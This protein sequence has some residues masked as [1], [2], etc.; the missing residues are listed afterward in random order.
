MQ[1][2]GE[3]ERK[4]QAMLYGVYGHGA[5]VV[6]LKEAVSVWHFIMCGEGRE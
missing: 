2:E 1:W 5:S 6:V 3:A 4:I